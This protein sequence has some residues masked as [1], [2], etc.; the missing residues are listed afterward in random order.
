MTKQIYIN[1]LELFHNFIHEGYRQFN[2]AVV[3]Y[4]KS[5]IRV[6]A[7]K[8]MIDYL[9]QGHQNSY[10]MMK[11]IESSEGILRYMGFELQPGYEMAFVMVHVDYTLYEEAWMIKRMQLT[12]EKVQK[13][14]VTE[15]HFKLN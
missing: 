3:S 2:T 5:D 9:V 15:F 4:A 6:F 8:F 13:G 1:V 11:P 7:P 10:Q 14:D 12:S